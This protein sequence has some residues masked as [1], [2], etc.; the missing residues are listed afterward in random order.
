MQMTGT[1]T[2][3]PSTSGQAPGTLEWQHYGNDLGG[4]R[5]VDVDQINRN[6]AAQLQPAWVFHTKV[7]NYFT[8][9]ESQPIVAEN[10][11]FVTSPH[12]HVF[13]LDPASG[14][15]KWTYNPSDMPPISAL[16][17]CCGQTNRGVAYGDGKVF[18]L[19]LDCKLV[20][21]DA[22]T[23]QEVWQT[24]VADYNKGY[25]ETM[26]PQYCD[27][28][29]IVGSSGG[30]FMVRGFVASYDAKSGKEAWRFY[31]PAAPGEPGGDTWTG[32][33]WKT[34]GGTVWGTPEV[35][36]Q[37]GHVYVHTGNPAPDMNG[38]DREGQNLFTD[39]IVCLDL[40]SGKYNWH[41]QEVHHD[42]WDYDAVQPG[43]LYDLQLNGQ[44]IPVIGH[45]GRCGFYFILDRRNGKPVEQVCQVK[46]V[47]V[48]QE[49][50]WQHPW[51]TQ[52]ESSISLVPHG[53]ERSTPVPPGT[54]SAPTWTPPHGEPLVMQPGWES[55]AEWCPGAY[56]PRTRYVYIPAGGYEPWIYKAPEQRVNTIGGAAGGLHTNYNSW[57]LIEAVDTT[58]GK[59]AWEHKTNHKTMTGVTVAG[60]LVF[61]GDSDGTFYA[62][63]AQNGTVLW[64]WKNPQN[65]PNVGGANGCPAVYV[66]NGQEYVVMGFGGCHSAREHSPDKT[67]AQGDALIAF[68]LPS[69]AQSQPKE[70]TAGP[71]PVP[72]TPLPENTIPQVSSPPPHAHVIE[73][74]GSDLNFQ[75]NHI[76]V[77][78]DQEV[79]IH[80]KN[81][82]VIPI[83][84]AVQLTNQILKTG[85]PIEPRKDVYLLFRAPHQ[86]GTYHF[87]HP[88]AMMRFAGMKGTMQV[89][90]G[91][92][93]SQ[94]SGQ[95]S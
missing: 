54:K 89:G 48:P 35:D 31:T 29:V 21:L 43:Q 65:L 7:M 94:S 93:G 51:P 84:F 15:L 1:S 41:F 13:A 62:Q 47:P 74:Q 57:G 80:L 6:N 17:I 14:Q 19:R 5:F 42:L 22:K 25:T 32:D 4:M 82:G 59:I 79:A 26:C 18:V 10:T 76:Q 33:S 44:T 45:A 3:S 9:F 49:P 91:Q 75:P 27:G 73:I 55:G 2:R 30:E 81:T 77:A 50:S 67:S 39:S 69:G 63:E 16:A 68:A 70:V 52:P 87:Y 83:E 53:M 58:T 78:P 34:G 88:E 95:N 64:Q 72:L 37:L 66:V 71:I 86:P 12:D 24:T 23:G 36:P 60:D 38:K 20:A 46:E 85:G 90:S 40:H 28:K 11:L 61:W 8:S 92:S 56:S